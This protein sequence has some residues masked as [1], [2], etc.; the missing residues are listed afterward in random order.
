MSFFVQL[1]NGT[2]EESGTISHLLKILTNIMLTSDPADARRIG[3][4]MDVLHI[5]FGL[6]EVML[7]SPEA[8]KVLRRNIAVLLLL[9]LFLKSDMYN[10]IHV[11]K[12]TA[13]LVL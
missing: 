11:Y 10:C 8:M 7:S 13:L 6:I 4:E 1:P 2:L 9:F 12:Y 5:L 3:E